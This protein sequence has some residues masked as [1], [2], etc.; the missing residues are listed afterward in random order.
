MDNE[1][2]STKIQKG[3]RTYFFDIRR[4]SRGDFYLTI[5]ESKKSGGQVERHRIMIFEE[6]FCDFSDAFQK[7][8]IEFRKFMDR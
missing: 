8:S 2:F 6:D 1:I 4:N 3:S 7:I 5:S